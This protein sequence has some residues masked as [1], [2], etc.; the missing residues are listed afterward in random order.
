M[1][2]LEL[3]VA[4]FAT[5]LQ[6]QGQAA[7]PGPVGG[8]DRVDDREMPVAAAAYHQG[9]PMPAVKA[10]VADN[11]VVTVTA[12]TVA[13]VTATSVANAVGQ[14]DKRGKAHHRGQARRHHRR[15]M[16]NHRHAKHA[17]KHHKRREAIA[18]HKHAA[19]AGHKHAA[20]AG[21]KHEAIVDRRA[22]SCGMHAGHHHL[23]HHHVGHHHAHPHHAHH[24]AGHNP[25]VHLAHEKAHKAHAKA[26]MAHHNIASNQPMRHVN[27]HCPLAAA[28]MAGNKLPGKGHSEHDSNDFASFEVAQLDI[29]RVTKLDSEHKHDDH[30][31]VVDKEVKAAVARRA[32]ELRK[33]VHTARKAQMARKAKA[34]HHK[35]RESDCEDKHVKRKAH[36]KLR[37]HTAEEIRSD[38]SDNDVRSARVKSRRARVKSRHARRAHDSDM[39]VKR[40]PAM[41]REAL[42]KKAAADSDNEGIVSH[43]KDT[44]TDV[45]GGVKDTT[46]DVAGHVKGAV[47]GTTKGFGSAISNTFSFGKKNIKNIVGNKKADTDSK[48]TEKAKDLNLS[49]V[50][51][52]KLK[53][54]L[55]AINELDREALQYLDTSCGPI[56]ALDSKKTQKAQVLKA[57]QENTD[58][59]SY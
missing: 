36:R 13:V 8:F 46:T 27:Q 24:H 55:K 43:V 29:L 1:L 59:P 57:K 33:G 37:R 48:A 40:R 11:H 26:H 38:D 35:S 47:K 3:L 14:S 32:A 10:A 4:L 21:H 39:E 2:K 15:A 9:A 16:K 30:E 20:V 54:D 56:K 45:T 58:R 7:G 50:D 5:M 12:N 18:G 23:G 44:T 41:R 53:E 17:K 42:K 51:R 31:N 6:V 28:K 19:V 49:A 34:A 22:E 25:K 52:M